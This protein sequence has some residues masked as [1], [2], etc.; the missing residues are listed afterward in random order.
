MVVGE[1]E[2]NKG[3]SGRYY[4]INTILP[5]LRP[6]LSYFCYIDLVPHCMAVLWGIEDGISII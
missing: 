6:Y 1:E 2:I 4:G 5:F 3:V